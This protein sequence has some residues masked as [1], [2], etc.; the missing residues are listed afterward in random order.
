MGSDPTGNI[1]RM[2]GVQD[3]TTGLALRG[4]FV[5]SP[6]GKLFNSE[7]NFYNLGRSIDDILRRVKANVYLSEHGD[8]ACPVNW[9]QKGDTTLKP[10]AKL[11][12][13]VSE[14]V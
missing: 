14:A 2:F 10:S 6:D 13:K 12:G 3:E 5:I 4:T 8:E 1:A 11:V 9:Q 7:V